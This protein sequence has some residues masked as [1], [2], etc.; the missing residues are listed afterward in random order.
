MT[1]SAALGSATSSLRAIQT[2][3]ALSSSN[4]A[5][6]D[7]TNYSAK[8]AT[9]APTVT[10]GVGSGV[11]V[12]GIGSGVDANL[13]RSI[14][15]STSD[16]AAAQAFYKFM[17]ALSDTL[18]HVNS[19]G[20]GTATG[21]KLSTFQ[22][23]LD[24]LGSTPES[25]SLKKQA[26]SALDDAVAALRGNSDEI[27]HQRADADAA[28]AKAVD[29]AN[30]ALRD[31]HTLNE[32][33]VRAK[34]ASQPTGDLEDLRNAALT[35]LG[36]QINIT[37]YDSPD[38][39]IT[40]RSGSGEI[41][42]GAEVHELS[43]TA[44]AKISG[45]TTYP[46][47]LSG[48]R[49]NGND[50][51]G[52]ISSGKI[53]ALI[54]L[55]D[56]TLPELQARLDAVAIKLKDALNASANTGSAAPP[57]NR[58]VGT[59][60]HSAADALS[61]TGPLRIAI[62]D[63]AG[64]VVETRDLDLSSYATV[65]DLIGAL[66]AI[67]GTTAALDAEGHLA[68]RATA[69]D[70]G[71]VMAGGNIG[72]KSLSGAFGLNDLITGTGAADLAVK[73]DLLADSTRLPTGQI[74]TSGPLTAGTQAIGSGSSK[75]ITAIAEALRASGATRD[76]SDLVGDFG[77]KTNSAKARAASAETGLTALTSRFSSEYGVNVDEENARIS[78]LQSAYAA[79]AQVLS[80]VKAMFNDLL[81][82]VR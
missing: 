33:I 40:V 62:T 38:G 59:T 54:T 36:E 34:A 18:G 9:L 79:S 4:I 16:N 44:S 26:V 28:L 68:V 73:A 58:L 30:D 69:T 25:A 77:A 8:R 82:A 43:F 66:N 57:P 21:S 29:T 5:N 81:T 14:V 24:K 70:H 23:L 45:A 67:P 12:T 56:G 41:L 71:I 11:A 20:S 42:V 51:S 22:S 47:D 52:A 78:Q 63:A 80:A 2:R 35:R 50:I 46:T 7:N 65:G 74:P 6:A 39:S 15:S 64:K 76:M 55:R 19:D 31:I 1:L 10:G 17:K 60:L 27:Q 48:V 49:V 32:A 3:L 53:S 61:A 37:R 13:M 75:V 72:G